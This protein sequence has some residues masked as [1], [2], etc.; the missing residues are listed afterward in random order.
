MKVIIEK[1][2][3]KM[4]QTAGRMVEEQIRQKPDAILG[5]AT[6]STPLGLYKEL[7]LKYKNGL[8]C[9]NISTFNLD[10]YVGL[11]PEHPQSY[12]Y[13]MRKNLFSHI[14]IRQE[15]IF[16]PNGI[17]PDL[18]KECN[19]YERAIKNKGG[20]DLQILGIGRNGH[21]GFNEPGSEFDSK[22]RVVNL[23]KETI[24]DN[25]RFFDEKSDVPQKAI[26]MGIGTI[27]QAE[28]IILMIAGDSKREITKKFLATE[29][30]PEI[31]ATALKKH[32]HTVVLINKSLL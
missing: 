25:S 7:I 18:K 29:P 12:H 13:Y 5:L 26:T 17:A 3:E 21:I 22:T 10:E 28:K 31:P 4:S 30:T 20:V 15:N 32:K 6:G 11:A 23:S 1:N 24:K 2:Y 14:N 9:L 19:N 8:D 16:I 27:L